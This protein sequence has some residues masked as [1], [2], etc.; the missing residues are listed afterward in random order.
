M[1][2]VNYTD[3]EH[4]EF[5]NEVAKGIEAR[6]LIGKNDG[7]PHFCMRI[8]KIVENGYTPRHTHEW[9]H[10]M[11]IHSGSGEV[12]NDK[13]WI[14]FSSGT[15]IFIPGNVEHQIKNLKKEP[16]ILLCLIPSGVPEL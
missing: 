6:V 3:V 16:L 8:F 5:D 13:E 15:A 2:I 11:F 10:E 7:A 1:K 12:L 14:P 9:E 4:I